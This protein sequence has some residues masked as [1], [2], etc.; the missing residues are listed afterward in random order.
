MGEIGGDLAFLQGDH[1]LLE[2]LER[3]DLGIDV[4]R[5]QRLARCLLGQRAGGDAD[6]LAGQQ[7]EVLRSVVADGE[8]GAVDKSRNGEIDDRAPLQGL[9]ERVA[10]QVGPWSPGHRPP[11]G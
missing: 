6:L 2:R 11:S 10:D 7:L 1:H 8:S 9:G 3:H 5:R 4:E